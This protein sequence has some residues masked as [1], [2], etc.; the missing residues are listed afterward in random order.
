MKRL[1]IKLAA[2]EIVDACFRMVGRIRNVEIRVGFVAPDEE[3]G[4]SDDDNGK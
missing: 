4:D 2:D 3:G 1:E